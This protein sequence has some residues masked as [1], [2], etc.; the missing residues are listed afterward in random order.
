MF[1]PKSFYIYVNYKVIKTS[2]QSGHKVT[3]AT[4]LSS[5]CV[6]IK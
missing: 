4:S 1:N 3:V 5:Q 2:L 6:P